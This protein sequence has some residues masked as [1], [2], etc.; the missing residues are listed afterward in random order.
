M[1]IIPFILAGLGIGLAGSLH[2]IGMCGPLALAIPLHQQA[3]WQRALAIVVYNLGR[4][5][6]YATMGAI[7]GLL[8]SGL[9]MVGYQQALSIILGVLV[10][11]AVVLGKYLPRRV[12]IIARFH[13]FISQKLAVLLKSEM[14]GYQYLL[15]GMANGFLPCGLVYLAIA[16]AVATGSVLGASVLMMSFGLGT[17]PLMAILMAAG[18]LLSFQLRLKLKKVIP[19]LVI[20][21]GTIMI[22]RGLGLGIPLISPAFQQQKTEV[23]SCCTPEKAH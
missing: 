17:L 7:F 18:H 1:S 23:E 9:F 8:G 4:V 12:P 21:T 14:H 10:I 2:C 15:L 6:S 3:R 16:A 19:F 20:A 22:L 11:L 13:S 5:L